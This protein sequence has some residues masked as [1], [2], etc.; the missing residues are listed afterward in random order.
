MAVALGFVYVIFVFLLV[1]LPFLCKKKG[2]P[3][4]PLDCSRLW[5]IDASKEV[6]PLDYPMVL[7]KSM[8]WTYDWDRSHLSPSL[9]TDYHFIRRT[10][11]NE[12]HCFHEVNTPARVHTCEYEQSRKYLLIALTLPSQHSSCNATSCVTSLRLPTDHYSAIML[13]DLA[14]L[15]N[16]LLKRKVNFVNFNHV[17]KLAYNSSMTITFAWKPIVSE[18]EPSASYQL[19]AML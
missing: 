4:P 16:V 14:S 7:N 18:S 17:Y 5:A 12:S 11:S 8:V 9:F 13:S 6:F 2:I 15:L 3:D 10:P 19:Q 1:A